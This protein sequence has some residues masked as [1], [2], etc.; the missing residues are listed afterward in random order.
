MTDTSDLAVRPRGQWWQY[1]EEMVEVPVEAVKKMGLAALQRAG[2][3]ENDAEFLLNTSLDKAIQG[4]HARGLE[5]LPGTVRAALSGAIDLRA[6]MRIVRETAATALVEG[7]PKASGTLVCRAAMDLAIRKARECG[8]GW[9]SVRN[10]PSGILTANVAQA[11]EAGM[12]GMVMTQSYPMVAPTGG[13]KPLLGNAPIAFGVPAGDRD[14]VILDMALTQTSASGVKLAAMQGE[15]IPEGF[16]LD[17]HGNPTTDPA[18]FPAPGHLTHATQLARG[19][20]LPI[21]GSHKAYAFIFIV[22]LLTAAL[23]DASAPWEP[24][25]I[26]GG[27]PRDDAFRYGSVYMAL[28][29]A[30]FM[31]IEEFRR[32]VDAFIDD[33][34][35]SPKRA[36]VDE[37]LYP[38]E[39]SQ[40]LKR[41]RRQTGHF[42]VPLSHYQALVALSE[43]LGLNPIPRLN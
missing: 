40:R 32:Q 24:S 18:D 2:A 26:V 43:E 39:M 7:E 17:E 19:T 3:S 14:P 1:T 25:E 28:D 6:S 9:V 27:K 29:P 13:Y 12:V 36:G 22:S 15:T 10:F 21:G 34:K 4:D 20:L 8:I 37:I 30:A 23:A 41:Q 31:P 35:S 33:V 42:L 5:G 16:V 38:G 11:I